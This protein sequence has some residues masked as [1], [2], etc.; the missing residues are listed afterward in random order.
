MSLRSVSDILNS[1]WATQKANAKKKEP[2]TLRW[3]GMKSYAKNWGPF[4]CS[5]LFEALYA[6]VEI[7]IKI[8]AVVVLENPYL[9]T[10]SQSFS[11]G[12]RSGALSCHPK[13]SPFSLF[14]H[15]RIVVLLFLSD[16]LSTCRRV[17]SLGT[18]MWADLVYPGAFKAGPLNSS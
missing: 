11:D 7:S 18:C 14:R 10:I 16:S 3:K 17:P 8:F 9:T 13:W 15:C 6:F 1:H 4:M 12:Q 5:I 2:T